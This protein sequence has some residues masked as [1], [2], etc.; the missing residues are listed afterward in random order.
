MTSGLHV[1]NAQPK[2]LV[3]LRCEQVQTQ[4]LS[5]P[6]PDSESSR[7]LTGAFG[8]GKD[9]GVPHQRPSIP[10]IFDSESGRRVKD[11][12]TP[13][14]IYDQAG[15]A[16]AHGEVYTR[17]GQ[18]PHDSDQGKSRQV[19]VLD[20]PVAANLI[21]LN[22]DDPNGRDSGAA[23]GQ[24]QAIIQEIERCT[25]V[26][27]VQVLRRSPSV[28][29]AVIPRVDVTTQTDKIEASAPDSEI[30]G[31]Q[32]IQ[33]QNGQPTDQRLDKMEHLLGEV[34]NYQLQESSWKNGQ[35][36]P[37][38]TGKRGVVKRA[39]LQSSRRSFPQPSYM[40]H[41]KS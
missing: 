36:T 31:P 29:P 15:L 6:E 25:G 38:N 33:D 27:A 20:G 34:R 23:C 7:A 28:S 21:V 11:H 1:E 4:D 26:N 5:T 17:D 32:R 41:G 16:D 3:F 14:P 13:A 12:L 9:L 35:R 37:D 2:N 40:G 24:V 30:S 19:P 39:L 10:K 8:W 18:R 22:T